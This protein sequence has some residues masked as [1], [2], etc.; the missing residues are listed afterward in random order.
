MFESGSGSDLWKKNDIYGS[1][2]Q[3]RLDDGLHMKCVNLDEAK[4]TK[5]KLFLEDLKLLN[6]GT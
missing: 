1:A 5:Q 3:V 2:Q 6:A 4:V